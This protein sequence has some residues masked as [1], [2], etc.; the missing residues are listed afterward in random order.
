MFYTADDDDDDYLKTGGQTRGEDMTTGYDNRIQFPVPVLATVPCT[1]FGYCSLYLYWL[2]F[3]VPVL[4]TVPCTC[5]Y[6]LLFPV[7]P[8][9]ALAGPDYRPG[10]RTRRVGYSSSITTLDDDDNDI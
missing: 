7:F 3:P 10:G 8:V 9:A 1:S 2:L 4:A 5:T 6:W